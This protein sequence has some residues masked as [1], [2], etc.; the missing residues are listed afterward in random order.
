VT[1]AETLDGY[2]SDVLEI[3][4]VLDVTNVVFVGHSVS[5][6]IGV[7]AANQESTASRRSS[8]G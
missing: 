8:T 3:C 6:M 5:A 4:R 2:A 7:L 1:A